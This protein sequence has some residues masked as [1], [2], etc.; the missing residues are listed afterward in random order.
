MTQTHFDFLRISQALRETK[1]KLTHKER[2]LNFIKSCGGICTNWDIERF[3]VNSKGISAG[4]A[5]RRCREMAEGNN[6]IL[7]HPTINNIVDMSSW[8]IKREYL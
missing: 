8:Q 1:P 6:S 4:S 5:L 7:F 2:V 3:A